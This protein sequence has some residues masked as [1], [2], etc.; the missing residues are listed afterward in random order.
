[1]VFAMATLET[2]EEGALLL[3]SSILGGAKPHAKFELEVLGDVL[4]LRPAGQN[5]DS[6]RDTP[7]QRAEAFRQWTEGA[8]QLAPDLPDDLLRREKFYD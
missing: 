1:M 8:R 3:P 5:S 4:M 6:G 2:N 7:Q